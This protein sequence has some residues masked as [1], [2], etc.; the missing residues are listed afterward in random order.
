MLVWHLRSIRA[1]QRHERRRAESVLLG[2]QQGADQHVAGAFQLPVGLQAHPA[3]KPVEDERLLNLRKSDL[4]R[5]ARVFHRIRG[6]G[7]RTAVAAADQNLVGLRLGNARGDGSHAALGHQL[8]AD[9]RFGID[10]LQVEDQLGQVLDRI[11]V[12]VRRRR[13]ERDAGNRV[14]GAG[15]HLIDLEARQLTSLARLRA[16]GDLD[17][18]LVG[19]D[20]ILRIDAETPRCDLLHRTAQRRAVGKRGVAGG[21]LAPFA[22]VALTGRCGSSR[23]RASRG[24][25]G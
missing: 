23:P 2:P 18:N 1:P 24:P 17:L 22:G 14:A 3:A 12:V 15:D 20:Q 16:L 11:D 4:D 6:A 5:N 10:I 9:E 25:R 19:I 13:D 21:V 8:H 7:T